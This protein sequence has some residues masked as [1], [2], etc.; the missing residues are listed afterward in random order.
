MATVEAARDEAAPIIICSR[1]AGKT[2]YALARLLQLRT[3]LTHEEV[4]EILKEIFDN[5]HV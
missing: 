1:R 2:R 5:G 4:V 3:D